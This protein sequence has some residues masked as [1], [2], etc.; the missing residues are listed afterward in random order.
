MRLFDTDVP[1][2]VPFWLMTTGG[3]KLERPSEY[4]TDCVKF[5]K[6]NQSKGIIGFITKN[7]FNQKMYM[8][9]IVFFRMHDQFVNGKIE[10]VDYYRRHDVP[11]EIGLEGF[12]TE[13]A[14]FVH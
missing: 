7:I 14:S 13:G 12:D 3:P 1:S 8:P 11:M 9:A 2:T 4:F 5:L 10:V 6:E